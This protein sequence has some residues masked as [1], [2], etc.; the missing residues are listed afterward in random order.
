MVGL[1]KARYVKFLKWE[2]LG[3][4]PQLN[5]HEFSVWKDKTLKHYREGELCA[6]VPPEGFTDYLGMWP[7]AAPVV[8]ELRSPSQNVKKRK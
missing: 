5:T 6:T 2:K 1:T 8:N 3:G 7:E 4:V